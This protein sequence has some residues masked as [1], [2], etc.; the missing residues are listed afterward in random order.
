MRSKEQWLELIEEQSHS[1]LTATAFCNERG[2]NPKYFSLKKSK[3]KT[4]V[5]GVASAGFAR[6]TTTRS[7]HKPS[8]IV[9]SSGSLSLSI[10]DNCSASWLAQLIRELR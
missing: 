9:L 2:I 3:L 8:K 1:G 10:P 4:S 5:D 7:A 6:C